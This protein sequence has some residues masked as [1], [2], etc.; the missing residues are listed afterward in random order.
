ML[1]YIMYPGASWPT[2]ARCFGSRG[3]RGFH[4][5]D[6]LPNLRPITVP[7]EPVDFTKMNRSSPRILSQYDPETSRRKNDKMHE[8]NLLQGAINCFLRQPARL[9]CTAQ[10]LSATEPHVLAC[11]LRVACERKSPPP[12]ARGRTRRGFPRRVVE[13]SIQSALLVVDSPRDCRLASLRV[14]RSPW[15][16]DVIVLLASVVVQPLCT[17]ERLPTAS[18]SRTSSRT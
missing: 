6:E 11:R 4:Q 16:Q 8:I 3:S 13:P 5:S 10:N 1:M 17:D 2:M 9:P 18:P 15:R 12:T 14:R 7:H